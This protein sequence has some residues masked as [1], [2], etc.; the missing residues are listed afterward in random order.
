M[1]YAPHDQITVAEAAE[2]LGVSQRTVWRYLKSGRLAGETH[3]E[4]GL[5]RTLIASASIEAMRHE[6]SP[7]QPELPGTR[8]ER[9]ALAARLREIERERDALRGRV[10][11]LQSRLA[12]RRP[13][14]RLERVL[15]GAMAAVSRVRVG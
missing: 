7:G 10:A 6:R 2:R 15:G 9:D 4:P 1:S 12:R 14:A 8:A 5:Q 3:G 13:P 11:E